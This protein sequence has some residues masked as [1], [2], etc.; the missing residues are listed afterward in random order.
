MNL[1]TFLL[2]LHRSNFL[3]TIFAVVLVLSFVSSATSQTRV[4]FVGNSLTATN[5]LPGQL[6]QLANSAGKTV[7]VQSSAPGGFTFQQH[8]THQP[9]L[10]LL[11]AGDYDWVVF[12]NQS[13]TGAGELQYIR[14]LDSIVRSKCKRSLFYLTFAHPPYAE[15][16]ADQDFLT[17]SYLHAARELQIAVAPCGEAWRSVFQQDVTAPLWISGDYHPSLHG[18]YLNACVLY[19][20]IFGESPVGLSY[21]AGLPVDNVSMYQ[22]TAHT[23]VEVDSVRWNLVHAREIKANFG[24]SI[25]GSAVQWTDGSSSNAR[26]MHWDFGDGTSYDGH[27]PPLHY[28]SEGSYTVTLTAGLNSDPACTQQSISRTVTVGPPPGIITTTLLTEGQLTKGMPIQVQYN[29]TLEFEEGNECVLQLSDGNGSFN[30]PLVLATSATNATEGVFAA[31]LPSSLPDG[32]QYRLRVLSTKLGILGNTSV[33]I[34]IQ[35]LTAIPGDINDM[36][37]YAPGDNIAIPYQIEGNFLSGNIFTAELYS[38]DSSF[39]PVSLGSILS[40]ESG[41]IQGQIPVNIIQSG[42]K[43]IR[44]RSSSAPNIRVFSSEPFTV[45]KIVTNLPLMEGFETATLHDNWCERTVQMN[46]SLFIDSYY[47]NWFWNITQD[48]GGNGQ[49]TTAARVIL[50]QPDFTITPGLPIQRQLLSPFFNT[51]G[52]TNPYLRFNY[53]Y[54]RILP[55]IP[56]PNNNSDSLLIQYYDETS[57][58]LKLLQ[59]YALEDLPNFA[60]NEG[61]FPNFIPQATDWQ[62]MTVDLSPLVAHSKVQLIFIIKTTTESAGF[63]EYN[64]YLDDIE[65]LPTALP[66]NWLN[67]TALPAAD[68]TVQLTWKT[69]QEQNANQFLIEHSVDGLT[70]KVIDSVKA[71]NSQEMNNYTYSH[72]QPTSGKNYYRL[73]AVDFDGK[74]SYSKVEMVNMASAKAKYSISP[75]PVSSNSVTVTFAKPVPKPVSYTIYDIKGK[76]VQQGTLTQQLQRINLLMSAGTYYITVEEYGTTA[77]IKTK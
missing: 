25:S 1:S 3:K 17:G 35:I 54:G 57:A 27:N 26:Y 59:R 44:I 48:A 68:K 18:Q 62:T 65:I 51:Q 23:I 64:F 67:F 37:V 39:A 30:N 9:T 40:T 12:Q 70:Y 33:D 66:L 34:P 20:S 43:F 24:H 29:S 41:V 52:L 6:V 5:D 63:S 38:F 77:F 49:S 74:Y 36:M 14:F 47:A 55:E 11:N 2:N 50:T 56:L 32:N 8:T 16:W 45:S 10:D 69:A 15:D 60:I 4:L 28:Y 58:E 31:T 42:N 61:D 13:Q 19:K 72:T 46:N 75:N 22:Q 76:I 71:K 7:T 73:R 53:A 21:A